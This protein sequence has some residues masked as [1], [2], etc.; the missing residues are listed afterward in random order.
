MDAD[1]KEVLADDKYEASHPMSQQPSSDVYRVIDG[2]ERNIL[3]YI[4]YY[5]ATGEE[6]IDQGIF[7]IKNTSGMQPWRVCG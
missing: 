6:L 3:V 4:W 1:T 2:R 5:S 7:W